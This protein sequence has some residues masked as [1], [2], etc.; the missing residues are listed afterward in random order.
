MVNASYKTYGNYDEFTTD[1]LLSVM[2]NG[3][4]GVIINYQDY[5]GFAA[6]MNGKTINGN[7]IAF[8]YDSYTR[9]DEEIAEARS[10][11]GNIMVAVYDDGVMVGEAVKYSD[12]K[13]AF[14]DTVYFVE[15]SAAETAMKYA[16]ASSFVPFQIQEK[17]RL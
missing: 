9:F 10:G 1:L 14:A 16:I 13:N 11:D 3:C 5:Q 8:D 7:T 15:K 6:S 4:S 2:Q 12:N 17:I